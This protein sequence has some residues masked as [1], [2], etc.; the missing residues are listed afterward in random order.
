MN[1]SVRVNARKCRELGLTLK[2]IRVLP[3]PNIRRVRKSDEKR[4]EAEFWFYVIA[5]CQATR[6][7]QG[8]IEGK[9]LRGGDYL[10]A[11]CRRRFDFD[12]D[13]FTANMMKSIR[14]DGLKALLSDD[15]KPDHSTI[16]RAAERV[17][18]LRDCARVLLKRFEGDI[19][20]IHNASEGYLIR[21]DGKGLLNLLKNFRAYSD[22]VEKKSFLLLLYLNESGIWKIRDLQNL[23]IAIDYHIMRI[24]LRAGIVNLVNNALA[25]R[26]QQ[27]KSVK[28]SE[29]NEV[30]K[31][32][33]EACSLLSKYS[34]H[35]AFEIDT[36]LWNMGRSCCFYEHDPICDAKICHKRDRCS[37][38]RA[39][40][41]S[42]LGKCIFDGACLGSR[43]E[44]YRK[45][46]ETNVYTEYY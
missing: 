26:L 4:R 43:N 23:E 20:R 27:R 40:N 29:D 1:V 33:R 2:P 41:Y 45:L 24:A 11:A 10:L 19:M 25:S 21:R 15:G 14:E 30:R 36:M 3:D 22:P 39:T 35:S 13:F 7:L 44:C 16:D 42:C 17:G 6:T 28:Q 5:M 12:R 9:W 32:V 31:T 37:F 34:G 18:L 8:Y 38:I 46:W